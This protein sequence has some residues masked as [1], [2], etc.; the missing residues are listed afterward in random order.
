MKSN[1]LFNFSVNKENNTIH[2]QREFDANID[3]VWKAWTTAELL[4]QWWAPKPWKAETKTMDFSVG[5]FWLYAM[6][7]PK[8]E[9]HWSRSD[10][11]SIQKEKEFTSNDNF[12]DEEGNADPSFSQNKWQN[13]FSAKD[14][15]TQVD[16][17]LTFDA[18]EDLEKLMDMGFKEGFTMGLQNLDQ[19]LV[20]LKK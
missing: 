2:V 3:L 19:L 8:G 1:L 20:S 4:D 15:I 14:D 7:G 6:V 13:K 18:L 16:V 5:G 10:Y 12:C 9:K 11:I 17:T